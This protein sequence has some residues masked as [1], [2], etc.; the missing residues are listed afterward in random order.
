MT[1][2]FQIKSVQILSKTESD[3]PFQIKRG[4][5]MDLNAL[6]SSVI[7]AMLSHTI[8]SYGKAKIMF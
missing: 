6:L 2:V 8:M 4:Q 5:T 3:S 7:S 1:L